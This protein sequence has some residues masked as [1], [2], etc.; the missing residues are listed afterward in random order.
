[1]N[2]SFDDFIID[3]SSQKIKKTLQRTLPLKAQQGEMR[4]MPV[5]KTTT[6]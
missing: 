3:Y 2:F 4:A 1:M 5:G 6:R